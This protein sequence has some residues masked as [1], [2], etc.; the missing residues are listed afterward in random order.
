MFYFIPSVG[1][2]KLAPV[3]HRFRNKEFIFLFKGYLSISQA[4]GIKSYNKLLYTF[5]AKEITMPK[6]TDDKKILVNM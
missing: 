6:F 1:P 2:E 4:S 5:I 3:L